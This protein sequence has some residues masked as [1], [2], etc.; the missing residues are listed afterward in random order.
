MSLSKL[1]RMRARRPLA[2]SS[3]TGLALLIHML[4]KNN[5]ETRQRK[6]K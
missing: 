5:R 4:V 2:G 3:E 1:E 6:K